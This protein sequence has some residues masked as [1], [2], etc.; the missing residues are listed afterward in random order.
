[1]NYFKR[2][3]DFCAVF[4]ISAAA[5]Y[6]LRKFMSFNPA[7]A[8][9]MVEKLKLFF[10]KDYYRDYRS[11]IVLI[12]LL[13][14]SL[15]VGAVLERFPYIGFALSLA[16]M[17]QILLM[18]GD[19]KLY[20]RPMLYVILGIAH[21]LGNIVHSLYLDRADGKRRGFICVNLA[22]I[23]LSALGFWVWRRAELL[24]HIGAVLDEDKLGSRDA[25]ILAGVEDGAQSIILKL[26][27]MILVG[28]AISIILRDVYFIDAAVAVIPFVYSAHLVATEKLRLF[29]LAIIFITLFYLI[30]RLLILICEPM[31]KKCIF[32]K[33]IL[34]NC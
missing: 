32:S 16:P 28:V 6:T 18:F 22:G 17:L 15:V 13:T 5:I 8:E 23:A 30:F 29:P 10:S 33:K 4:A 12:T 21:V 7:D 25:A 20:E 1:M 14:V 2:F 26:S 24:S 3:S 19:G 11:Y 9:G 27:L 34:N 31:S